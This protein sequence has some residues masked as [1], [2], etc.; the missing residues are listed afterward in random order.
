MI[1]GVMQVKAQASADGEE[2]PR[3]AGWAVRGGVGGPEGEA[4]DVT[5]GIFVAF[6]QTC[7]VW[8]G[9][10]C[11]ELLWRRGGMGGGDGIE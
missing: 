7:G 10:P 5:L 4:V 8:N 3:G 11:L 6:S 1:V 9:S 2:I